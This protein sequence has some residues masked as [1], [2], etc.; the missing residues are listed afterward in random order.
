[1]SLV[2]FGDLLIIYASAA[3]LWCLKHADGVHAWDNL[4]HQEQQKKFQGR[5]CSAHSDKKMATEGLSWL[6]STLY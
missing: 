2:I 5:A 4:W 3:V 6:S 1:M